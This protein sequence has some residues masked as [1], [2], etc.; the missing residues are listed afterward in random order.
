MPTERTPRT[1]RLM[2]VAIVAA[3]F[4]AGFTSGAGFHR[5][6]TA[7]YGPRPPPPL[8]S[9]WTLRE[10]GLSPDQKKK[11]QVILERHRPKLEAIFQ[12]TFPRVRAVKEQVD[13]E[14]RAIL[15]AEQRAK[16]EELNSRRPSPERGGRPPPG[17]VPP[18]AGAPYGP[19]WGG[20][21]APP[22]D[23]FP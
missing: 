3:T 16:F 5:W 15:S 11:A 10:L 6:A 12:E 9:P 7:D 23:G 1:V 19:P 2:T 4:A 13:R 17:A 18:P 8:F 14:I 20:P 21:L 22:P